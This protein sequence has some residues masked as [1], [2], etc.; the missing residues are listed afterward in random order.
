LGEDTLPG[1][2]EEREVKRYTRLRATKVGFWWSHGPD[3][4]IQPTRYSVE[5]PVECIG[6]SPA[7]VS[8][9]VFSAGVVV[10]EQGRC[11]VQLS[12]FVGVANAR[13]DMYNIFGRYHSLFLQL[14]TNFSLLSDKSSVLAYSSRFFYQWLFL[15]AIDFRCSALI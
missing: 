12:R 7:L 14:Q 6:D 8:T 11:S 3:L 5:A 13:I 10:S 2:R 4:I 1:S 9:T 15:L